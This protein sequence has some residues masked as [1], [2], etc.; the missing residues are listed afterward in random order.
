VEENSQTTTQLGAPIRRSMYV[1]FACGHWRRDDAESTSLVLVVSPPSRRT[2]GCK[3]PGC[4][5]HGGPGKDGAI[6][7]VR[8]AGV[9]TGVVEPESE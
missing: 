6:T 9:C 3:W 8:R 4:T 5:E 1:R 7:E 2:K